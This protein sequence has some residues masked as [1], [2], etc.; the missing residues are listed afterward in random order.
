MMIISENM[1]CFM[2]CFKSH[3]I[4]KLQSCCCRSRRVDVVCL[5]TGRGR[6]PERFPHNLQFYIVWSAPHTSRC[7]MSYTPEHHRPACF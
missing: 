7:Q 5:L 4:A 2:V 3:K 6:A 1:V